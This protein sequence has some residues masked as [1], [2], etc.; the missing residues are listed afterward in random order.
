[1]S[2]WPDQH[3]QT[4]DPE[5]NMRHF[6]PSRKRRKPGDLFAYQMPDGLWGYIRFV[7]N[8]CSV[9]FFTGLNLLY[10]Y[11]YRSSRLEIPDPH[12]LSPHSLL[13]APQLTNNLGWVRGYYLFVRHIPIKEEDAFVRHCF[14]SPT[15]LRYYDEYS[16]AIDELFE[17]IGVSGVASYSMIDLLVSRA[18]GLDHPHD[19]SPPSE[20]R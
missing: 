13:L 17:P 6:A 9:G 7:K 20:H 4:D 3:Y 12:H 19:Q 14:Y 18:L 16:V 11:S 10:V 8:H 15:N 5:R 2:E 1:M